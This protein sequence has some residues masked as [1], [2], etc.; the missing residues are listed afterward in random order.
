[1]NGHAKCMRISL[2]AKNEKLNK[3]SLWLLWGRMEDQECVL[4]D[5][6]RGCQSNTEADDADSERIPAKEVRRTG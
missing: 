6:S 3:G 5:K 1:M 2:N 4:L